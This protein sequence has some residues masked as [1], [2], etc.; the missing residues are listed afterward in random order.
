M[1]GFIKNL[2][3]KADNGFYLELKDGEEVKATEPKKT[4]SA[5][6]PKTTELAPTVAEDAAKSVLN[7]SKKEAA[8]I[9]KSAKIEAA[10]SAKAQ[11]EA[12]AAEKAAIAARKKEL[13]VEKNFATKYLLSSGNSERR[14]PGANMNAFLEMAKTAKTPTQK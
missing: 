13:P 5:A 7:A 3:K 4:E 11:K 1:L 9:A 6:A 12:D 10:K 8:S 2:A 14:R